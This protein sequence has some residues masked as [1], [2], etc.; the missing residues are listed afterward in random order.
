MIDN[1]TIGMCIL[2]HVC[3]KFQ[4][5][6]SSFAIIQFKTLL[7]IYCL[8]YLDFSLFLFFLLVVYFLKTFK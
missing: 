4:K 7:N 8:Q 6:E 1:Y 5:I 3:F 2:L